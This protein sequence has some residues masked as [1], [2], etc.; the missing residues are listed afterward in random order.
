MHPSGSAIQAESKG[1]SNIAPQVSF[2][3]TWVIQQKIEDLFLQHTTHF[4]PILLLSASRIS[5]FDGGSSEGERSNR[6]HLDTTVCFEFHLDK[7][8]SFYL[9]LCGFYVDFQM[10]I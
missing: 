3:A 7:I 10:W 1:T 8:L 6:I 9:E 4:A 2:W 5:V